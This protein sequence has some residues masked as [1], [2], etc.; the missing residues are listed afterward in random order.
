MVK[1][2]RYIGAQVFVAIVAVLGII[3][4]LALLFAFVDELGDIEDNYSLLDALGY[5]LLT[6]PRRIYEMLPMAALIG[7]LLGSIPVGLWVC[8]LYG[9]DIRTVGS[10]RTGGTNAWRAAGPVRRAGW[11]SNRR[12]S[13]ACGTCSGSDA[14]ERLRL[15]A[16]PRCCCGAGRRIAR[17]VG[18][19]RQ[20]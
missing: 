1:L 17:P 12:A 6:A 8:R 4:G 15:L 9:V 16:G 19:S 10:G 11:R 7:Y 18:I 20:G 3:V 13:T 5:V 14:H 2:D